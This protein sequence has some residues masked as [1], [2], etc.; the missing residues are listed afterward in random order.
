[1]RLAAAL[2][3]LS[4]VAHV[5]AIGHG[6]PSTK[7]TSNFID[8]NPAPAG[9]YSIL[10]QFVKNLKL[11][12]LVA[13]RPTPVA[14]ASALLPTSSASV[15]VA[16]SVAD[17][18]STG[19]PDSFV[20]PLQ[21]L[22]VN[23]ELTSE[24]TLSPLAADV[25]SPWNLTLPGCA[26]DPSDHVLLSD[27]V[28][29]SSARDSFILPLQQLLVNSELT[30]ELAHSPLAA[31]V[32]SPWNLTLPG[33]AKDPADHALFNAGFGNSVSLIPALADAVPQI[34][35]ASAGMPF[36]ASPSIFTDG[37]C[38]DGRISSPSWFNPFLYID[39]ESRRRVRVTDRDE[40]GTST[41][42]DFM[43]FR[44]FAVSFVVSFFE[45]VA[46]S[47]CLAGNLLEWTLITLPCLGAYLAGLFTLVASIKLLIV[48]ITAA[49]KMARFAWTPVSTS[50]SVGCML[51]FRLLDILRTIVRALL[52]QLGEDELREHYEMHYEAASKEPPAWLQTSPLHCPSCSCADICQPCCDG[53]TTPSWRLRTLWRL[54]VA[55]SRL[56][57]R[58]FR[59]QGRLIHLDLGNTEPPQRR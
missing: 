19:T 2:I 31:D 38:D 41:K 27:D 37:S 20:L 57:D 42:K 25:E 1:M 36:I 43:A 23:S 35:G 16:D 32:E 33:C 9:G 12:N 45:A 4:S 10:N 24:L 18:T 22:L 26:T 58:L 13:G 59:A 49:S 44:W 14:S 5:A 39:D 55:V 53:T 17:S 8:V 54:H 52:S 29:D 6:F 50:I 56:D 3:Y 28:L 11:A 34:E 30:P 15:T 51:L 46:I 47:L 21:Q 48:V 40:I 7:S